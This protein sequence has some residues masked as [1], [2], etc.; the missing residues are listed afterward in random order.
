MGIGHY[1]WGKSK[2]GLNTSRV[3]I[4]NVKH[5]L[6]HFED[7]ENVTSKIFSRFWAAIH[8]Q[9]RYFNGVTGKMT[10]VLSIVVPENDV[11]QT[12]IPFVCGNR[13]EEM[14]SMLESLA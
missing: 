10:L 6:V 1:I 3:S 2:I 7:R 4:G 11:V 8:R 9:C 14:T 13:R 12:S 5:H